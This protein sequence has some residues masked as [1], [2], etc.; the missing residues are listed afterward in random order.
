MS[1]PPPFPKYR[2]EID[3]KLLKLLNERTNCAIEIGKLKSKNNIEI[4]DPLREKKII[5]RICKINKGPLSDEAV[6]RLFECFIKE[7]RQIEKR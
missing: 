6:Q 5:S 4:Y 3:K 2:V 1:T 7:S